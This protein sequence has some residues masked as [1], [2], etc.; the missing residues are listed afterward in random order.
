MAT[1]G[2]ARGV[3][4]VRVSLLEMEDHIARESA[5][6]WHAAHKT[7]E[8]QMTGIRAESADLGSDVV[9]GVHAERGGFERDDCQAALVA[10]VSESRVKCDPIAPRGV[11][12]HEI[13]PVLLHFEQLGE[14]GPSRLGE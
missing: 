14:S 9:N 11:D 10:R 7:A 3:Q 8:L 12:H 6:A 13:A 2:D 1:L 5:S 4:K